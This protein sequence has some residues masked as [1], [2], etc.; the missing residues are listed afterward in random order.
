[1]HVGTAVPGTGMH[2]QPAGPDAQAMYLVSTHCTG[3]AV[4]APVL[5]PPVTQGYQG[6]CVPPTGLPRTHAYRTAGT[7]TVVTVTA[8]VTTLNLG[9]DESHSDPP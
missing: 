9:P 8:R 1:M 3:S 4:L 5:K 2:A 7:Q 6:V